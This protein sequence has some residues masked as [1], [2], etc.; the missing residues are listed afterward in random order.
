MT[1]R[2]QDPHRIYVDLLKRDENGA[3]RL[4][5]VGTRRDLAAAGIELREGLRVLLYTDDADDL[6]R[7]DALFADGI[8]HFNERL[9]EW[10]AVI[11]DGSIRH[12]SDLMQ[13]PD[14]PAFEVRLLRLRASLPETLP[15][16]EVT[17]FIDLV[18]VGEYGVAL[19]NLCTQLDEYDVVLPQSVYEE[20]AVIG[21]I[22]GIDPRYWRRL[23]RS[24]DGATS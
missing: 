10:V 3:V 2:F 4:T 18:Q 11:D 15:T 22:M 5:T 7:P 9:G 23:A 19:E 1:T 21:S 14:F 13:S 12:D 8:I 20:I 17:N 24:S 16:V 6:G